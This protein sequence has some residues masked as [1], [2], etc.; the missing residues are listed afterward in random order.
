MND[1]LIVRAESFTREGQLSK[2]VGDIYLNCYVKINKLSN[3]KQLALGIV[4]RSIVTDEDVAF[5]KALDSTMEEHRTVVGMRLDDA[6]FNT[7]GY[8]Q[9][10]IFS[11]EFVLR[12]VDHEAVDVY[13]IT[14]AEHVYGATCMFIPKVTKRLYEALGE[15][16]YIA[17]TSLHEALIHPASMVADVDMVRY[18]L[19]E[20]NLCAT[21]ESE[22]LTNN[23]YKYN[24]ATN[25]IEMVEE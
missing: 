7:V 16:Y 23:V 1:K 9:I 12:K 18:A 19:R 8:D 6:I 3:E 14:W 5:A 13:V 2:Q 21:N 4:P 25:Q 20:T 17:F 10:D 11:N 22:W 24:S 15:E